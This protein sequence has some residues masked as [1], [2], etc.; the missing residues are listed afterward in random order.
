MFFVLSKIFG[1]FAAPTNLAL[2]VA[3]LGVALSVTRWRKAGWAL[4]RGAVLFLLLLGFTPLPMLLALPLE[5]RFPQLPAEAPAPDGVIVLGGAIDEEASARNGQAALN[6][7]AER[8]TEPLRLRRLYPHARIVFTGGSASLRGSA[9]TEA[10]HVR[11]FWTEL[12]MDQTGALYEDR[13]RNTYENAV[14]TRE[15][16]APAPGERWLLVTSAFHM[17]RAMGIFRKA[18]FPVVAYPVDYRMTGGLRGWSMRP[19]ALG[20]LELAEL[21]AHEWLGLAAYWLTGKTD[22]L[23]PAP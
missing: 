18:G 1:F 20:N 22:A 4:V 3:G 6:D 2:F 13:S 7:A 8:L 15:R 9:H 17:P 23:F 10:E 14:F 5:T 16:L 19:N 21:A 12:G 11:T